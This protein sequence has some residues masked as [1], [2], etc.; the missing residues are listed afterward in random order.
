MSLVHSER[1]RTLKIGVWGN[2][3]FELKLSSGTPAAKP[4]MRPSRPRVMETR[5]VR[6]A[7]MVR[8]FFFMVK[9]DRRLHLLSKASG[10]VCPTVRGDLIKR[11]NRIS[12]RCRHSIIN[13]RFAIVGLY[14]TSCERSTCRFINFKWAVPGRLSPRNILYGLFYFRL[15]QVKGPFNK[16]ALKRLFSFIITN[17]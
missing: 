17:L 4:T 5:T 8:P 10:S 12:L 14:R 7:S 15:D 3:V 11:I 1:R 2:W 13:K 6:K 16:T 9:P